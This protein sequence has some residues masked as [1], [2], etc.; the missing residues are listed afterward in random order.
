[1]PAHRR[2]ALEIPPFY[3]PVPPAFRPDA[4]ELDRRSAEWFGRLGACGSETTARLSEGGVALVP[5]LAMPH[6]SVEVVEIATNFEYLGHAF[7]EVAFE[8]GHFGHAPKDAAS[9]LALMTRVIEVP[10][11]PMLDRGQP[12]GDRPARS[13]PRPGAP[14]HARSDVP[15]GGRLAAVLLRA[16]LGDPPP[17]PGD[18]SLAQ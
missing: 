1:M 4:E 7:D 8:T 17:Q 2:T 16:R 18:A 14:C 6:G 9:L 11:A 15:L 13:A 10:E 12:V 5:G 3:C